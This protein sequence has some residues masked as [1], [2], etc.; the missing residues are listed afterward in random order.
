MQIEEFLLDLWL[1]FVGFIPTAIGVIIVLA[2]G[3]IAGRLIGKGVSKVLD[4]VGVDDALKK[5]IIG[6]VLERAGVTCVR[7]FDLIVRWFV[8]LI[9]ILAA[10]DIL[11]IEVLS[12]LMSRIVQYLPS[13][14]AGVFILMLGVIVADFIGDSAEAFF[15][16]AKVAYSDILTNGL[17]F[18]M[19]F[20]VIVMGLSVMKVDVTI[21]YTFANSL[22]WGAAIGI[23]VGLGIALGW[24]LKDTVA[25]KAKELVE[26]KK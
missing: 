17:K 9:A 8:Y 12:T 20:I 2:I 25:K 3:W 7:F 23:G 13:L 22:A 26:K 11:K 19:Y 6:R 16:E 14:I 4:K 21:L 24:G 5:T 10:V 18:F 1:M 15:E